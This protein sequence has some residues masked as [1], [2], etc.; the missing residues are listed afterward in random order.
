MQ[1]QTPGC[2][3]QL[4]TMFTHYFH[5]QSQAMATN[6]KRCHGDV[7]LVDKVIAPSTGDFLTS[8]TVVYMKCKYCH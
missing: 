5:K 1:I 6:P 3:I 7:A 8:I 2:S 4:A